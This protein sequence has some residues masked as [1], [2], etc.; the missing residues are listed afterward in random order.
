MSHYYLL[1]NARPF[2]TQTGRILRECWRQRSFD[3]GRDFFT[4]LAEAAERFAQRYHAGDAEPLAAVAAR[5]GLS[6]DRSRWRHLVG[7]AL[8][9]LAEDIPEIQTAPD[10]YCRL[11][12][13]GHGPAGDHP[14]GEFAPVEQALFG[15]ADLVFGGYYRPDQAGWNDTP[16][17][18]RL[19]AELA[20]VDPDRWTAADLAGL[21]G[22]TDEEDLA[23]ELAFA[24]EWFPALAGLY[25]RAEEGG[26]VVV[27][28]R[29]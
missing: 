14:R 19:A 3:P 23:E 26:L 22:L 17:V 16:A 20:A 5:G 27:C 21:P 7:E 29:L 11:L 12:A 28:E 9:Y 4:D 2:E 10:A 24:Q 1:H 15:S 8:L 25:R 13:P 18:A 6:F